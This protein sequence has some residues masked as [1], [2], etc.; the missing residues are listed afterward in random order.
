MAFAGV[1]QKSLQHQNRD[2]IDSD[3]HCSSAPCYQHIASRDS[4]KPVAIGLSEE[5]E[6][7]MRISVAAVQETSQPPKENAPRRRSSVSSVLDFLGSYSGS[8]WTSEA[9]YYHE[10][11]CPVAES[12]ASASFTRK[13]QTEHF[14]I[15][16]GIPGNLDS[17]PNQRKTSAASLF[18]M[19]R[20][21]RRPSLVDAMGA[22]PRLIVPTTP[23]DQSFFAMLNDRLFIDPESTFKKVWDA[24]IICFILFL[25]FYIPFEIAFTAS[26]SAFQTTH[27]DALS[28]LAAFNLAA[29]VCF[30]FDI[31]ANFR[32]AKVSP[33]G[34]LLR[35]A[36]SIALQY[37][38]SWFLI[39]LIS[40]IPT[41]WFA[42]QSA[43]WASCQIIEHGNATDTTTVVI[44]DGHGDCSQHYQ[45]LSFVKCFRLLRMGRVFKYSTN[46]FGNAN[47]TRIARMLVFF[48]LVTHIVACLWFLVG[49]NEYTSDS[50]YGGWCGN[51]LSNKSAL[52]GEMVTELNDVEWWSWYLVSF[53]WSTTTLTT[54]GYG[55]YVPLSPNEML[56]ATITELL[57]SV[58][59]AVIFGE[60]AMLITKIDKVYQN[61]RDRI[62]A[63]NEFIRLHKL[64]NLLK[65]R[66]RRFVDYTFMLTHGI[67]TDKV[68]AELPEGLRVEIYMFLHSRM[69]YR[70][71]M[72]QDCERSFIKSVVMKLKPQIAF[73]KETICTEGDVG[74]HMFFIESGEIEVVSGDLKTLYAMLGPSAFVGEISILTGLRRTATV[75]TIT[76][77]KFLLLTKL[78]F[79]DVLLDFSEYKVKFREIAKQ[80]ISAK[81]EQDKQ[82]RA[83]LRRELRRSVGSSENVTDTTQMRAAAIDARA[84]NRGSRDDMFQAAQA[85]ADTL[86]QTRSPVSGNG[87][88]RNHKRRASRDGT[89]RSPPTNHSPRRIRTSPAPSNAGS[90]PAPSS[91]ARR[92]SAPGPE[93]AT[94]PGKFERPFTLSPGSR[95]IRNAITP[96]L[97]VERA[98]SPSSQDLTPTV[99]S[100]LQSPAPQSR[101]LEQLGR[102]TPD[103]LF[104]GKPLAR[105]S[106]ATSIDSS[107]VVEESGANALVQKSDI[108]RQSA[109]ERPQGC[110]P[111][112]VQTLSS[113]IEKLE[114]T[115]A[116]LS[117]G[118]KQSSDYHDRDMSS[119]HD[120]LAVMKQ[121]VSSECKIVKQKFMNCTFFKPTGVSPSATDRNAE[122][123]YGKGIPPTYSAISRLPLKPWGR[124][125]VGRGWF[126][127]R[128]S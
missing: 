79:E 76:M 36:R 110:E 64:P 4:G 68:A 82:R 128:G 59:T 117:E 107:C 56:Y 24:L 98:Q 94:S 102:S 37:V 69:V 77:C 95:K 41:I 22:R 85:A 75:L 18:P 74:K 52:T 43:P 92:L 109:S 53:Y 61:Y 51:Y 106:S 10:N 78:D 50:L 88:G 29:N 9:G 108:S 99:A 105:Q 35:D 113:S 58:L 116:Q 49:V 121:Y 21:T 39:D 122:R 81:R 127:G 48:A 26:L 6:N 71:P 96:L 20:S 34:R 111:S 14:D 87:I 33:D 125:C 11:T 86:T 46:P 13:V 115:V 27:D 57:G 93:G 7:V 104:S 91:S 45:W 66:V 16:D 100:F 84:F 90:T 114:A 63:A 38:K 31:I 1:V 70:V 126:A 89:Q 15:D 23:V 118:I 44:G 120:N 73:P 28:V 3:D 8:S 124:Y 54:V 25:A 103:F 40:S 80:R 67:S 55:D 47:V 32:T 101:G 65:D 30:V 97:A 112:R 17:Y 12:P 62:D 119:L 19:T 83:T 123:F 72:F 60:M 2:V 42:T 5:S